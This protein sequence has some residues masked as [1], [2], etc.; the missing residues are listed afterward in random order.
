MT[1]L[2]MP[3]LLTESIDTVQTGPGGFARGLIPYAVVL[4]GVLAGFSVE[5]LLRPVPAFPYDDPYITLH[6]AQVL[7]SG[8]DPNYPGVP[9]LF[10][11]TSAPFAGLIYL[12]LFVL[13]PL[14]ALDVACWIGVFSYACGLVYLA[15]VLRLSR[16]RKW[17][18]VFIGLASAP[19]PVHWLNGLETSC[20]LA[21]VTWTLGFASLGFTSSDRRGLVA[22]AF[23][24][25]VSASFRPDLLPF[26]LLVTGALAWNLVH[27]SRRSKRMWVGLLVLAFAVVAPI[28]LCGFWYWH[29][30]GSPIPLTGVAKRYFFA[31]DHWPL[32]RRIGAEANGAI[33]FAAAL[34]PLVLTVPVMCRSRL[35]KALLLTL[36]LFAAALFVQFPAEFVV[37]EFRYPVVL[38]PM[39]IWGLGKMLNDANGL[40]HRRA[41]RLMYICSAY[42]AVMLPVCFHFYRTERIFFEAGP[43]HVTE[44]CEKN[45]A[46]GTTVLVH[47]AGYL[48]YSTSFRT[49]DFVGLKTP[50]AI[51]VN[52]QYTWPSA[53][54]TRAEAVAS[55][56]VQSG[57][58]YLI[59]NAIWP[60]VVT[61]ARELR[62]LGWRVELLY[63]AGTFEIFRIEPPV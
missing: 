46:P 31:E 56:A 15:N 39:L 26:A 63:R 40:R 11:V 57:T 6:S 12:L 14:Q 13:P 7:H 59:L 42:A 33:L 58:R 43:S 21:A 29:Q 34:G 52:R 37:N 51:S 41:D 18:V 3:E 16:Y 36:L 27:E 44:W 32:S 54:K 48:A 50:S 49:V 47:D 28:L 60:P 17:L 20:A 55:I 35:G 53:G 8:S 45:L 30:T 1:T 25:G 9:A 23:L 5:H 4:F 10:G 2:S 22:A 19:V 38:V 62:A 61:L 24:A